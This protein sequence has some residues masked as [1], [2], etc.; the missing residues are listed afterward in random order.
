MN[1]DALKQNPSSYLYHM[2]AHCVSYH[3]SL[4]DFIRL[5]HAVSPIIQT[6]WFLSRGH[7][8]CTL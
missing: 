7:A 2:G 3:L 6:R 8:L 1:E 5:V 4:F